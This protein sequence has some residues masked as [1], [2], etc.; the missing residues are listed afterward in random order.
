MFI[1]LSMHLINLYIRRVSQHLILLTLFFVPPHQFSI[2]FISEKALQTWY[3][4]EIPHH[5]SRNFFLDGLPVD[6]TRI[7]LPDLVPFCITD[8]T[9]IQFLI[10]FTSIE[11]TIVRTCVNFLYLQSKRANNILC[12]VCCRGQFIPLWKH[13][14]YDSK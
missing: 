3:Y 2:G 6:L 5:L 8:R 14:L 7:I 1:T 11:N 13:V 4:W 12:F 9:S 10:F